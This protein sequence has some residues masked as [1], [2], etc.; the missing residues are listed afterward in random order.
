[1]SL[2][3][4]EARLPE[5]YLE[6]LQ[7]QRHAPTDYENRLADALEAAFAAGVRELD[8]LLARLNANGMRTPEGSEWTAADFESIIEKLG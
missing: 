8:E 7:T 2:F 3:P 1:M 4:E 5:P 6:P